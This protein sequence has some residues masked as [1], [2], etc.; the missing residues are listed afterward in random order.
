MLSMATFV[1]FLI[2]SPSALAWPFSNKGALLEPPPGVNA[3]APVP[4]GTVSVG[5]KADRL[6]RH[7]K[8]TLISKHGEL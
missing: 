3:E 6:G 1:L 2:P 5:V 7:L 8:G 4:Q